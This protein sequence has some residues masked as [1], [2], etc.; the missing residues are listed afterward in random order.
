[1]SSLEM[2]LIIT[3]A[4][5]LQIVERLRI[6]QRHV[7]GRAP[8]TCMCSDTSERASTLPGQV[9]HEPQVALHLGH[10]SGGE[11]VDVDAWGAVFQS[12][13]AGTNA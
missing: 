4:I 13:A 11:A 5:F 6:P 12:Q 10:G 3:L 8:Y 1:M 2:P 9:Y 7:I